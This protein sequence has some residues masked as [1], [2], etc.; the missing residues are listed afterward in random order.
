MNSVLRIVKQVV[1]ISTSFK[2]SHVLNGAMIL[3][4]V[5]ASMLH[6]V[7]TSP[8]GDMGAFIEDQVLI[9]P[10]VD[11]PVSG[12][13]SFLKQLPADAE[14]V[15]VTSASLDSVA[16]LSDQNYSALSTSWKNGVKRVVA[17]GRCNKVDG[18]F[19]S[20]K[21]DVAYQTAWAITE[22]NCNPSIVGAAGEIG[23]FQPM[24][25]TC[26]SLG[27][28][29]DLHKPIV[30]ATCTAKY[31]EQTCKQ[32]HGKCSLR[33]VFL[34]HNRGVSGARAVKDP[35]KAEYIRKIDFARSVL[36]TVWGV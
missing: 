17:E 11:M 28:T 36:R 10:P 16:A 9:E 1:R 25:A 35:Q 33:F 7:D 26:K 12:L 15:I 21:M 20:M 32:S 22:S 18:A 4:V 5:G 14:P 27:I 24:P 34:A 3:G 8:Y 29:G 31:V 6:S 30:N 23:L 13:G 2:V 19:H